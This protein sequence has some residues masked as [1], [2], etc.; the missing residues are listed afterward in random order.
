MTA[1]ADLDVGMFEIRVRS[2]GEI[3]ATAP[4]LDSARFAVHT[5][6]RD[7]PTQGYQLDIFHPTT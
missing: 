2:T 7:A 5:I 1:A 4:D 3:V 6:L